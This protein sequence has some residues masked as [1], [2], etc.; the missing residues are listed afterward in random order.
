MA[1]PPRGKGGGG[2]RVHNNKFDKL[3]KGLGK[4]VV[5]MSSQQQQVFVNLPLLQE[6]NNTSL[7]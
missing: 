7:M 4:D 2:G 5:P 1:M 6:V 3:L